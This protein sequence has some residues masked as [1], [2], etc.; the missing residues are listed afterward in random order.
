MRSVSVIV[1][2]MVRCCIFNYR[3]IQ[4]RPGSLQFMLF[5]CKFLSAACCRL[6]IHLQAKR[7]PYIS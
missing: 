2:L 4:A 1:G 7:L 3:V 6:P 5:S